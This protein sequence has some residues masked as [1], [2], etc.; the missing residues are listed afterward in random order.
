M[1]IFNQMNI[2]PTIHWECVPLLTSRTTCFTTLTKTAS[3]RS[4]MGGFLL[5]LLWLFFVVV[6]L[7]VCF[8]LKMMVLKAINTSEYSEQ[9]PCVITT[10]TI[11]RPNYLVIRK[12]SNLLLCVP[13]KQLQLYFS[14]VIV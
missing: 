13:S 7:F 8:W 11:S 6:C 9:Y 5:L 10:A 12:K 2:F 3:R 14:S 1:L 4:K